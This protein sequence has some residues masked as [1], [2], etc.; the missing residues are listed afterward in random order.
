LPAALK[1]SMSA[2]AEVE[3]DRADLTGMCAQERECGVEL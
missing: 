3:R 2:A 1:A